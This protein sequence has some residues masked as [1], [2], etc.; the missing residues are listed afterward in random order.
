M[1]AFFSGISLWSLVLLVA[2]IG[3]LI[4]EIF[5]PGFG[6]PGVLGLVCLGLDILISAQT[7]AQGLLMTAIAAVIVLVVFLIG[8]SLISRGKL[9][10]KLVLSDENG[11]VEG[12]VSGDGDGAAPGQTGRAVTVLRPA[13]IAEIGGKRLDVVT[14]GEFIPEGSSLR[15]EAVEGSRIVVAAAQE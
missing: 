13:G 15:V 10:K 7:L 14:Q 6:L 4:G 11:S 9:P 3:F 12:F 8:A 1:P 2:G 5:H